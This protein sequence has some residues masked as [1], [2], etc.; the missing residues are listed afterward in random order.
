[1]KLHIMSDLHVD[2]LRNHAFTPPRTEAEVVI[3]AGDIHHGTEGLTWARRHFPEQMVI[4]VAGNHEYYGKVWS[5]LLPALRETAK[6]LGI[7]FLDRD[8]VEIDGVRFLGATLW[9]DFDLYGS[10]RREHSM[11]RART[12]MYDYTA[13]AVRP[14]RDADFAGKRLVML[15][16]EQTRSWSLQAQAWLEAEL[17]IPYGG[18]TVV[19]THH[20]PSGRSVSPR[21]LGDPLNPAFASDLERLWAVPKLWVHGHTHDSMDYRSPSG[22]RVLC[23]PRGYVDQ[24]GRHENPAFRPDLVVEVT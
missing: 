16:P 23:N 2:L 21:F 17:A 12:G 24:D 15:R 4:Y 6:A 20:L 9:T 13:I 1:M 7:R 8:V 18:P 11:A 22:M 10:A 5:T 14:A 19:V 3:L